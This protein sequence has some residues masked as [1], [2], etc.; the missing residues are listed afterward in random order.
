MKKHVAETTAIKKIELEEK[1]GMEPT[2]YLTEDE[3]KRLMEKSEQ[4]CDSFLNDYKMDSLPSNV[5]DRETRVHIIEECISLSRQVRD[6]MK[7]MKGSE[8]GVTAV[9]SK[10]H[11]MR[12]GKFEDYSAAKP[13]RRAMINNLI[14]NINHQLAHMHQLN[15][16]L[17]TVDWEEKE[18]FTDAVKRCKTPSTIWCGLST[19]L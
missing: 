6:V 12:T 16:L 5:P 19:R 14:T 9:K 15:K 18:Q 17:R 13:F 2:L 8:A 7:S 4:C 1:E 3:I 11:R 10:S